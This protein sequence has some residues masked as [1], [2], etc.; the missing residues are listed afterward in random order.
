VAPPTTQRATFQ[1]NRS[2]DSRAVVYGKTFNIKN[3]SFHQSEKNGGVEEW[4]IGKL[5]KWKNGEEAIGSE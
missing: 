1:E 2:S 5:E 4:K 3:K